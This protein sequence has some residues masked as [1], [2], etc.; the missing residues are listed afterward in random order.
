MY[1]R[2]TSGS[3]AHGSHCLSRREKHPQE[4][5]HAAQCSGGAKHGSPPH[6][7]ACTRRGVRHEAVHACAAEPSA[8]EPRSAPV[9]V[10]HTGAYCRAVHACATE[11]VPQAARAGTAEPCA[12]VRHTRVCRAT[13]RAGH[14]MPWGAL[15]CV[16]VPGGVDRH[17]AQPAVCVSV[18]L[19]PGSVYVCVCNTRLSL[20]VTQL[21]SSAGTVGPSGRGLVAT[22][23]PSPG[24][25]CPP[26]LHPIPPG[27]AMSVPLWRGPGRLTAR[28][29]PLVREAALPSRTLHSPRGP[30]PHTCTTR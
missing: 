30:D 1:D 21:L 15:C 6:T 29:Q 13:S 2:E 9:H 5:P 26:P 11:R 17:R 12:A 25:S 7:P 27:L 20:A 4:H 3:C 16:G 22:P 14:A 8:A 19:L 18:S 23:C 24:Q 10:C 28:P